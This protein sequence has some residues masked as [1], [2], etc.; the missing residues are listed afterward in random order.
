MSSFDEQI[1]PE[2]TPE[3][4]EYTMM[5]EYYNEADEISDEDLQSSADFLD[6]AR[7]NMAIHPDHLIDMEQIQQEDALFP[8]LADNSMAD[9]F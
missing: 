4:Q 1:H 3:Y 9:F 2:E 5:E 8:W 6:V 7:A